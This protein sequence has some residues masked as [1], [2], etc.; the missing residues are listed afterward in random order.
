MTPVPAYL[1]SARIEALIEGILAREGGAKFTD[2]PSDAGGATRWGVTEQ[3]ARAAGYVGPMADLPR[4]VAVEIYRSRYVAPFEA[5]LAVSERIGEELVDTEVNLPPGVAGAWLQ[6][7]LNAFNKGG[8]LWP[9]LAV[10]G[11][12]GP[13]TASALKVY[14]VHRG[15]AGE[16]VLLWALNCSQGAYYLERAEKRAQNEDFVYGWIANRVRF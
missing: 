10:D 15:E 2:D 12:A 8:T 16:A 3:V 11:R 14:L 1:R 4:E 7:W 9:D 13:T 6:R 5:V